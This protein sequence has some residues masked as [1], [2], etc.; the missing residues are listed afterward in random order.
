MYFIVMESSEEL[1]EKHALGKHLKPIHRQLGKIDLNY[2]LLRIGV[3]K[4]P[5]PVTEFHALFVSFSCFHRD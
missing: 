4:L 5:P 1:V 3:E 2:L